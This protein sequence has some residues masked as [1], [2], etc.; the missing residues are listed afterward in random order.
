[1]TARIGRR[2]RQKR[3]KRMART[4]RAKAA[5]SRVMHAFAESALAWLSARVPIARLIREG[6]DKRDASATDRLAARL[7]KPR[8]FQ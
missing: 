5:F 6:S 3:H 7:L 2:R 4:R 1:M 8:P